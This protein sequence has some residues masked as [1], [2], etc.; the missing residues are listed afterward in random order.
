MCDAISPYGYPGIVMSDAAR[1]TTGFADACVAGLLEALRTRALCTAFVRLHPLLNADLPSLLQRYPVTENGTTVS[2]DLLQSEDDIWTSMYRGHRNAILRARRAGF[3]V[4]I[5]APRDRFADFAAVYAETLE[6]LR[7][8]ATYNFGP[9]NL[10]RLADLEDAYLAVALLDGAVAGAYLFFERDGI[11]QLHLGGTRSAY[12]GQASPSKLLFHT[13][14]LWAKARGDK[15][16]HFGGGVGGSADDGLFTF[17]AGF[18]PRRHIFC[19]LRLVA[20]DARY[21]ELVRG[22]ADALGLR[23]EDLLKSPFFPA[24]RAHTTF[25]SDPE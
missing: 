3:C 25:D 2:I 4:E 14:A 11:V 10:R 22:R 17:K 9:E 20:D 13:I 24:Y 19:T 5:G 23:A 1:T 6:R 8:D 15:V 12:M 7:A 18:S 21:E 16:L